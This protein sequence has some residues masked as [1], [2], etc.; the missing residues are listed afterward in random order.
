LPRAIELMRRRE[1]E[2]SKAVLY[3]SEKTNGFTDPRI[4][5]I[6]GYA[7]RVFIPFSRFTRDCDFI[8]RKKNG[9]NLDKL[10]AVMPKGYTIESE[11]RNEK[12]GFVR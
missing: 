4:V 5:L 8:M 10:K 6:G 11:Q 2:L 9:W 7:L 3:L 1:E 12:Y